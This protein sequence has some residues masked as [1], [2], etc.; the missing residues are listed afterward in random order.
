MASIIKALFITASGRSLDELTK[1]AFFSQGQELT[2]DVLR[3]Y[4]ICLDGIKSG[5]QLVT[6]NN[7]TDT[8]TVIDR[9]ALDPSL[10]SSGMIALQFPDGAE[11]NFK[12]DFNSSDCAGVLTAAFY[13]YDRLLSEKKPGL[14][15]ALVDQPDDIKNIHF[16]SLGLAP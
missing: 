10:P 15:I 16:I 7:E 13:L 6:Y 1:A 8:A 11:D 4:K 9:L 12:H 5:K 2:N 14:D 3:K